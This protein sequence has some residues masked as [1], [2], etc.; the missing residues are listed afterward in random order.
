MNVVEEGTKRMSELEDGDEGY[1]MLSSG[2]DVAVAP[3]T[4]N[5]NGYLHKTGS[6]DT[7]HGW[8]RDPFLRRYR[9][10]AMGTMEKIVI[11]LRGVDTVKLNK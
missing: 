8:E 10:V 1:E 2:I 3:R 7:C 5:N 6:I 9:Q 4:H 11:F